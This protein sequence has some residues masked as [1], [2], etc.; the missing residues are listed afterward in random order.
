MSSGPAAEVT[1]TNRTIRFWS[2]QASHHR[3]AWYAS[4]LETLV[5]SP[6]TMSQAWTLLSGVA[7]A[8]PI[9]WPPGTGVAEHRRMKASKTWFRRHAS[10]SVASRPLPLLTTKRLREPALS[11][12]LPT[13][14]FSLTHTTS[15]LKGFLSGCCVNYSALS[16]WIRTEAPYQLCSEN[17]Q[18]AQY[19]SSKVHGQSH[20]IPSALDQL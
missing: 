17:L 6:C 1:G 5:V 11:A 3:I 4:F 14:R 12:Q 2:L 20:N 18:T 10:A 13:E 7:H 15:P 9:G 8:P 16:N 19:S